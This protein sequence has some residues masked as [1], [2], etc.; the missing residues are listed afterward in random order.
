MP[1]LTRTACKTR[2]RTLLNEPSARF[3]TE[4]ELNS[5][6]DDAVRDISIKT[7][8]VQ[9]KGT[10]FETVNGTHTYAWPD[11]IATTAVATLGI[12]TIVDSNNVSLEFVTVDMLGR[13]NDSS[14][15]KFTNWKRNIIFTPTPTAVYTYTP[16]IM[17]VATQTAAGNINLP[18]AYHHLVPLY[19]AALGKTKRRDMDHASTIFQTY[20]TELSRIFQHQTGDFGPIDDRQKL[21]DQAPA[22]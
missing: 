22:D 21:K 15:P 12:K 14:T 5:W 20:N 18:S 17:V 4:V 7:Y 8:C 11:T 9:H 13:V 16:Y 2:A 10:A 1:A 6:C 19:M 3:F